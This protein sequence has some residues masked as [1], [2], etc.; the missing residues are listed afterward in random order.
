MLE[1]VETPIE[2]VLI[3]SV[4]SVHGVRHRKRDV[5]SEVGTRLIEIPPSPSPVA[6][7]PHVELIESLGDQ[8]GKPRFQ[9]GILDPESV[10]RTEGQDVWQE[11]TD[12]LLCALVLEVL[13]VA[14]PLLHRGGKR[15]LEAN[16][17]LAAL[18]LDVRRQGDDLGPAARFAQLAGRADRFRSGVSVDEERSV[19]T[20]RQPRTGG[21]GKLAGDRA[22]CQIHCWNIEYACPPDDGHFAPAWNDNGL[23]RVGFQVE[24]RV[25]EGHLYGAVL[26]RLIADV[27]CQAYTISDDEE[28]RSDR[29]Y[30][31]RLGHE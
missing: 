2:H 5:G 22:E 1:E 17:K 31:K 3:H 16:E 12:D 28:P 6:V 4:A 13:E 21:V 20:G 25:A 18:E 9:F 7:L 24:S 23:H 8:S 27:G 29:P 19:G 26:G 11:P 10:D 14:E 30:K 15:R